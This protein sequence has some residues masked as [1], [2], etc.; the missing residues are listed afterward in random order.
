MRVSFSNRY[1][2]CPWL[3]TTIRP[4][5]EPP[6]FTDAAVVL[7]RVEA[8]ATAAMTSDAARASTA[9]IRVERFISKLLCSRVSGR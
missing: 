2:V 7:V 6:V 3:S 9:R 1:S 8:E 5:D 4:M